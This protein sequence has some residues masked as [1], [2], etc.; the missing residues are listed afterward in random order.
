MREQLSGYGEVKFSRLYF[1]QEFCERL[2]PEVQAVYEAVGR[3]ETE[4]YA[5]TLLTPYVTEQGQ[6]KLD[7]LLAELARIKPEA[8]VAANDWGTLYALMTRYLT[9]K[10]VLGRLLNKMLRDPRIFSYVGGKGDKG[11]IDM[12]QACMA[13]GPDLKQ[14]LKK[15]KVERIEIDNPPQGLAENLLDWGYRTSIYLPYGCVT[16]GRMCLMGSWGMDKKNKFR[17]TQKGCTQKC[18]EY[19]LELND[20]SGQVKKTSNWKLVQKGNTVFYLQRGEFL[21]SGLEAAIRLGVD[22]IVYQPEPI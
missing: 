8:E 12:F 13:A 21:V 20:K 9:L 10:P 7:L 19:W 22:R 11:K 3:A 15:N 1:G 17:A 16:T 4:N 6:Q 18:R 14:Y 5:F 2:I